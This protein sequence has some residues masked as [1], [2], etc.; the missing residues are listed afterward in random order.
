MIKKKILIITRSFDHRIG[1]MET[2]TQLVAEYFAKSDFIVD[3]LTPIANNPVDLQL[4]GNIFI[5]RISKQPTDLLKYSFAFW[6]GVRNFIKHHYNEYEHIVNISMAISLVS[7][8]FVQK[9]DIDITTILHG[10][11]ELEKQSLLKQLIYKKSL[12]TFLGVPYCYIMKKFEANVLKNS[13]KIIVISDNIVRDINHRYSNYKSK[14]FLVKNFVDTDKFINV[15]RSYK[16]RLLKLLYVGRLHPEKGLDMI[17]KLAEEIRNKKLNIEITVIGDGEMYNQLLGI[18]K[19]NNKIK[20]LGRKTSDEI[21]SYLKKSDILLFPTKISG[22]GLPISVLEAMATGLIVVASDIHSMQALFDNNVDGLLFNFASQKEF[23]KKILW[24][25]ENEEKLPKISRQ[26]RKKIEDK[27]SLKNNML[28]I[29]N[30]IT[31]N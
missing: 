19:L 25:L 11:Y 30:I 24:C 22:E 7:S 20:V 12:K 13:K 26:A 28:K 31:N 21:V 4:S 14:I 16:G 29:F 27:Y 5:K 2:H 3:V 8:A 9:N 17:V 1:G 15:D 6:Y 18:D 10:T 23:E